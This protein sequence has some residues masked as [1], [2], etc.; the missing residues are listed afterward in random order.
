MR[1]S[2]ARPGC[3]LLVLLL[4]ACGP[5]K[6][7]DSA[8]RHL[9][10]ATLTYGYGPNPKGAAKYQPDVVLVGGGPH[11][12]RSA[13]ANGLIWTI[14]GK[15]PGA[16]DLREGRI[17]FVTS[18]AVG[19]VVRIEPSGVDLAVT[20][21]PVSLTEVVR[22][23]DIRLDYEL[24]TRS[25]VYQGVP[26]LPGMIST[27]PPIALVPNPSLYHLA[28]ARTAPSLVADPFIRIGG[29]ALAEEL[30]TALKESFK[31]SVGDWEVEPSV[32][33]DHSGGIAKTKVGL[34]IQRKA[35]GLKF[36]AEATLFANKLRVQTAL[37]IQGG[38][39]G[40]SATFV[41]H[42]LEGVAIAIDAG[43]QNGLKDNQR[44]RV[45]VPV[46]AVYQVPPTP[47]TA[48]IPMV[49]QVKSKFIVSTAFSAR[50][51]VLNASGHFTLAGPLG[52]E[53]GNLM[54]PTFTVK[55]SLLESISGVSAGASGVVFAVE[56]RILAGV[57]TPAAMT[58]PYVKV[59][60]STGVSRGSDLG[61][62]L[63]VCRG[64]TLKIDVGT[65]IGTQVS[66]FALD[67]L[68]KLLGTS[69]KAEAELSEKLH[70]VVNKSAVTPQIPLCQG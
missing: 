51:S 59:I 20:L 63:A 40:S 7:G 21:A 44:V 39:V 48:G 47:E 3:T 15:A 50:N 16:A 26:D 67:V 8:A 12:I 23:A 69:I 62:A 45:E 18:R 61:A 24:D 68:K 27:P 9:D 22:D 66:S 14:D 36:G 65:G 52:L 11:A 13:S 43:V 41:V 4:S 2:V 38:Q 49:L 42:G 33:S 29:A 19:R 10:Q 32:K 30:P 57:G 64:G 54:T 46:E 6:N 53:G 25:I 17:M 34:R 70:T 5:G 58:G 55:R 56:S 37:P 1:L 60:V 28:S 31:V 35:P